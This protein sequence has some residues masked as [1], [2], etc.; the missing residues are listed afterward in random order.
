VTTSIQN[1]KEIVSRRVVLLGTDERAGLVAAIAAQCHA[2]GV[3]LEIT[4]GISHVL[5]TFEATDRV[6][7]EV[8]AKLQTVAGVQD[9][10]AYAVVGE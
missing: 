2:L 7:D 5:L 8:V 1:A 9:A 10:H 3:S 6:A 4:T